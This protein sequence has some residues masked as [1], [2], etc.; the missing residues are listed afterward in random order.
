MRQQTLVVPGHVNEPLLWRCKPIDSQHH[1]SNGRLRLEYLLG[2]RAGWRKSHNDHEH[3]GAAS[4]PVVRKFRKQGT[5]RMELRLHRS[6]L[7]SQ[8]T[9]SLL[10][11]IIILISQATDL[12]VASKH[13]R[14]FSE[15]TLF[16]EGPETASEVDWHILLLKSSTKKNHD[17]LF[18]V[19]RTLNAPQVTPTFHIVSRVMAIGQATHRALQKYS[20]YFEAQF[21]EEK[22]EKV[23]HCQ[24]AQSNDKRKLKLTLSASLL[25]LSL[26]DNTSRGCEQSVPSGATFA[27]AD[28]WRSPA[29]VFRIRETWM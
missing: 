27:T 2:T 7:A 12:R 23:R 25:F 3:L 13:K 5:L 4:L 6:R 19:R 17:N 21:M 9:D 14:W 28:V 16:S 11:H 20:S 26:Q 29:E 15:P 10:G 1:S 24:L 22:L 8:M 18:C